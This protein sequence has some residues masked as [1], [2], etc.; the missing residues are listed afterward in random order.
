VR[1]IT[2]N[3]LWYKK[4]NLSKKY[5]L[6]LFL[7][8]ILKFGAKNGLD[9][10]LKLF[11]GDILKFGA[12]NGLDICLKL[13]LGDILKFGAKNGLDICLKLFLVLYCA[14]PSHRNFFK[15]L[16]LFLP[17]FYPQNLKLLLKITLKYLKL[18]LK[19]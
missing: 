12:K 2:Y 13:F 14:P 6:N 11:L 19:N 10:C 17:S 1:S 4:S 7:G 15:Y 9:I 16:K 18:L 8:N 3:Y 5:Y